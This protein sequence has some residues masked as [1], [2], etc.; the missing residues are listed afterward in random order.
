MG[1]NN[2]GQLSDAEVKKILEEAAKK[3]TRLS[4]NDEVDVKKTNAIAN[5]IKKK[6]RVW[7]KDQKKDGE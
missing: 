4:L 1:E 3:R 7:E 6:G 2:N 5:N